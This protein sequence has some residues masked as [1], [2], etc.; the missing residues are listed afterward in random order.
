ML[1]AYICSGLVWNKIESV[2]TSVSTIVHL[3]HLTIET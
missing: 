3:E 1:F 2:G